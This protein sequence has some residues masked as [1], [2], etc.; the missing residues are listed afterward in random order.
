MAR[1]LEMYV[2]IIQNVLASLVAGGIIFGTLA[3]L[4]LNNA[5]ADHNQRVHQLVT[6]QVQRVQTTLEKDKEI[7]AIIQK[8]NVDAHERI[9]EQLDRILEQLERERDNR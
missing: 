2:P 1:F 8:Q 9:E 7:R 4:Y 6:M 3:S 5:F